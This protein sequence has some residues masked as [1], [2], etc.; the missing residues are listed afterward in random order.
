MWPD[1]RNYTGKIYGY[2]RVS[3]PKQSID[4]QISNI[5]NAYPTAILFIEIWTGTTSNRKEWQRLMKVVKYGDTIVFDSV[6]RMSRNAEEG[7]QD[8]QDLYNRGVNLVFL[9]EPHINTEVYK[10]GLKKRVALTGTD[11][12]P[13]LE[14]INEYLMTLAKSQIRLAF[15]ASQKEVD[16]LHTRTSE[17]IKAAQRK[18]KSVGRKPGAVIETQKAKDAKE[19]ILELSKD[20]YGNLSDSIILAKYIKI[21]PK[22]YYKYKREL[23]ETEGLQKVVAR[24]P[25]ATVAEVDH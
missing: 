15:E 6:S 23:R 21:T 5:K 2:P 14:G 4:R 17:G 24:S 12:D 3:T 11:V 22:T 19:K 9:K 18:G 13:I 16:D 25:V 20:F 10:Q 7:F 8:Y 1:N